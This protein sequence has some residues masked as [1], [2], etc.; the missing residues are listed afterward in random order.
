MQIQ[1]VKIAPMHE[2]SP[3]L[4]VG[5]SEPSYEGGR[6]VKRHL[7]SVVVFVLG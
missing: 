3:I 1:L 5:M 7:H 2:K 6:E 4:H